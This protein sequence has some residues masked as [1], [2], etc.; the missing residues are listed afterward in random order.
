[1]TNAVLSYAT[2][3]IKK[4]KLLSSHEHADSNFGNQ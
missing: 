1:M 3:P 2:F 4:K